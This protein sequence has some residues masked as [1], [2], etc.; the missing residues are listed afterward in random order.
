VAWTAS[1][2]R[3]RI[4]SNTSRSSRWHSA[5]RASFGGPL[6]ERPLR[7]P[8]AESP[9]PSPHLGT[10]CS[11]R[12]DATS[13]GLSRLTGGMTCSATPGV[14]RRADTP[15]SRLAGAGGGGGIPAPPDAAADQAAA[16]LTKLNIRGPSTGHLTATGVQLAATLSDRQRPAGR[17]EGGGRAP[18]PAERVLPLRSTPI[19][20][21]AAIFPNRRL[22]SVNPPASGVLKTSYDV[23]ATSGEGT[24]GGPQGDSP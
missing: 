20:I 14:D 1:T 11:R 2:S 17:A 6:P 3:P 18:S 7:F 24:I 9:D 19:G 8:R 5:R 13:E 23:R 10:T 22:P 16:A 21:D 15:L 12:I 4:P